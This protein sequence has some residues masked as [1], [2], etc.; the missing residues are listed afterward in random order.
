[1]SDT[2]RTAFEPCNEDRLGDLPDNW[3][4]VAIANSEGHIAVQRTDV[5]HYITSFARGLGRVEWVLLKQGAYSHAVPLATAETEDDP[6]QWADTRE[7][8][9]RASHAVTSPRTDDR[10]A[11]DE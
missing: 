5:D 2:D 3:R 8:L 9:I 1:M 10:E 7:A 11:D 6:A 4:R